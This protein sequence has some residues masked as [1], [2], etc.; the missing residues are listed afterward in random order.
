MYPLKTLKVLVAGLAVLAVASCSDTGGASSAGPWPKKAGWLERG[1]YNPDSPLFRR[2]KEE[3]DRIRLADTHEHLISEKFW[4]EQQDY[5]L[6]NWFRQPWFPQYSGSDLVS[7][8]M[9]ADNLE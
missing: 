8:G 6:F 7:A 2:I 9:S 4:L 3:V 5:S 1:S